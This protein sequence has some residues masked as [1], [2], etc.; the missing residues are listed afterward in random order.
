MFRRLIETW[1]TWAT[2]PLRVAL[3]L[4]FI[5]HGAQKVFGVWGGAGLSK[6]MAGSTPYAFMRPSWMWLAAA[7]FAELVGGLLVLC[8]LLTRLGALLIIPVMLVAMVGVHW[9]AFFMS[10]RGIEFTLALMGMALA[11]LIYGGG[12]AS[13]DQAL[14]RRRSGGRR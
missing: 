4:I 5:A 12:Q 2:L 10:N 7:A 9:G 13:F 14:S 1:P 6:W 3:G 8:G 11:L